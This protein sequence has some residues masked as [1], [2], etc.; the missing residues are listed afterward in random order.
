MSQSPSPFKE[1]MDTLN[2]IDLLAFYTSF[3]A[4]SSA[5]MSTTSP[6]NFTEVSPLTPPPQSPIDLN[7]PAPLYGPYL[8]MLSDHMFEGDL[9]KSTPSESNI[10][11]ASENM[12]I[13]SLAQMREAMRNEKGSSF[14]DDLLRDY[15]PVFDQT[16]EV[17]VPPSTDGAVQRRMVPVTT[18]G[19]QKVTEETPKRKCLQKQHPKNPGI[20]SLV[21]LVE[22]QSWTHLFM[23]KSPI[24]HEEQLREFYYNVKFAEDGNLNTLMGNKSLHLNKELLGKSWRYSESGPDPWWE[25]S[26]L[27]SSRKSAPNFLACIK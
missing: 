23:T 16:P 11:A 7:N 5:K 25:N 27:S 17:G 21:D 9:S 13:K 3:V 24:L 19:K 14:I 26:A 1:K 10:L 4:P 12:V 18:K 6:I 22:I 8:T 20:D 2:E 15:E